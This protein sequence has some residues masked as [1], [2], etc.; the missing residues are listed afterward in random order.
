[1]HTI[2]ID[3]FKNSMQDQNECKNQHEKGFAAL[4]LWK[5]FLEDSRGFEA[6]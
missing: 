4:N 3:M 2:N 5:V 1:M 6:F